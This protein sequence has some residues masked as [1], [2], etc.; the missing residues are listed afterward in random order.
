[1]QQ[2]KTAVGA[3]PLV[4]LHIQE[5]EHA[6]ED[7]ETWRHQG[8]QAASAR[9]LCTFTQQRSALYVLFFFSVSSSIYSL[10][11]FDFTSKLYLTLFS[12]TFKSFC[13]SLWTK[14]FIFSPRSFPNFFFFSSCALRDA[15]QWVDSNPSSCP[16]TWHQFWMEPAVW[17]VGSWS[18]C[19]P[20]ACTE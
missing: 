17:P 6:L 13:S 5:C 16:F 14:S 2:S 19:W 1:M 15:F 9:W 11:S 10:F 18:V 7:R 4:M 8:H 3:V 20:F 12:K